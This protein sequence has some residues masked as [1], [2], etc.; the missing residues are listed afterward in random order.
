VAALVPLF[1]LLICSTS[2]GRRVR[3]SYARMTR[4][5]HTILATGDNRLEHQLQSD[6][7]FFDDGAITEQVY[8]D[9]LVAHGA[10]RS[11]KRCGQGCVV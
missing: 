11:S 10:L 8:I 9:V 1:A 7:L 3:K 5:N 2:V 4:L 6:L